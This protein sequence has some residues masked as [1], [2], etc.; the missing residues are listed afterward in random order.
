MSQQIEES[1][2]GEQ[3][4]KKNISCSGQLMLVLFGLFSALFIGEIYSR[5]TPRYATPEQLRQSSLEYEASLFARSLLPAF[6]QDKVL[7]R[8]GE[9]NCYINERGYRGDNFEV[10]KPAD[11]IRIIVLGGSAAFDVQANRNEDW[12]ALAEKIVHEQGLTNVEII[13]AGSPGH[14]TF[15]SLGRLYA[16]IWTFEPDYIVIYHA[17]NDLKYFNNLSA[18]KTLL[19]AF[20]P[21]KTN[22]NN[23]QSDNPT[24]ALVQNPMIYYSGPVDKLLSNSQFYLR[25]RQGYLLWKF[26]NG[27]EGAIS[28]PGIDESEY[29]STYSSVGPKQFALNL[30]LLID[31]ARNVN[32][33]PLLMTQAHLP[34]A[35]NDAAAKEVINYNYAQLSHEGIVSAFNEIDQIIFEV[36]DEK[37]TAVLDLSHLNGQNE[38]FIDHVHTTPLGSQ[39]IA[40][41]FAAFLIEQLD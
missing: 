40:A 27:L 2:S 1:T 30:Q 11:T 24:D 20:D 16:E 17:W 21:Q 34:T 38:L 5:V 29:P 6:E 8:N 18:N 26:G 41:A 14:A 32:A 12:P 31:T 33:T 23:P 3:K 10:P 19:R 22:G 4:L 13:N 9:V 7:D 25:F 28:D 36:G 15:D 37:E 39:E 35:T